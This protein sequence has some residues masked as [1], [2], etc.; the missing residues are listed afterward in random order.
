ME[1]IYVFSRE[2]GKSERFELVKNKKLFRLSLEEALVLEDIVLGEQ[3]HNLYET[4]FVVV[5]H[6]ADGDA[7]FFS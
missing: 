6:T 2:V 3:A 1:Q 5:I 7:I 4:A